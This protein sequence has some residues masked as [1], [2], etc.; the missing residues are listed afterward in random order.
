MY[1]FNDL[2]SGKNIGLKDSNESY[3]KEEEGVRSSVYYEFSLVHLKFISYRLHQ[4]LLSKLGDDID[5]IKIL[6]FSE[7]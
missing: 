5:N 6:S 7:V 1:A 2:D 4:E 3:N